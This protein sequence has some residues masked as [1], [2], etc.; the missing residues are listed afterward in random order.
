[1]QLDQPV[2]PTRWYFRREGALH[3]IDLP[4]PD[5]ARLVSICDDTPAEFENYS[6]LFNLLPAEVEA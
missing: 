2:K 6:V 4:R 1:M 3:I 5:R